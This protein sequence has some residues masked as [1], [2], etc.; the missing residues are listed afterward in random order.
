[1]PENVHHTQFGCVS[2]APVLCSTASS[3]TDLFKQQPRLVLGSMLPAIF[4]CRILLNFNTLTA[5]LL[6]LQVLSRYS[7]DELDIFQR[8]SQ[9]LP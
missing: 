8:Y 3:V 9:V 6:L 1:M 5:V 7:E 2:F 4:K